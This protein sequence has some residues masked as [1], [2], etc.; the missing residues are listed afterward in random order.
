M[1]DH[2]VCHVTSTAQKRILTLDGNI[3]KWED[4]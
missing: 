1:V 2:P 3:I 4:V